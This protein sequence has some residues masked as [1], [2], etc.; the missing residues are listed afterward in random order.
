[1]LKDLVALE[2]Y[3]VVKKK[4]IPNESNYKDHGDLKIDW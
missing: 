3:F 4:K 1:M 2:S